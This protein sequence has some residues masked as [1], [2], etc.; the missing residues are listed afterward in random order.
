MRESFGLRR[1]RTR[2]RFK[3]RGYPEVV[4]A[5]A[6]NSWDKKEEV[7]KGKAY[8]RG[9]SKWIILAKPLGSHRKEQ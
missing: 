5:A 8:F 1:V 9:Q 4:S 6:E 2:E 7:G 3:E